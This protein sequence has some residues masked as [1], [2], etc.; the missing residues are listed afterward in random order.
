MKDG[1]KAAVVLGVG[2]GITAIYLATREVKAKPPEPPPGKATFYGLVANATTGNPLPGVKVTF[3]SLQTN[4]DNGGYYAFINLD[5]GNYTLICEKEGYEMVSR[6]ITL[7]PGD[8]SLNIGMVPIPVAEY[9][10]DVSVAAPAVGYVTKS[11]DKPAYGAGEVVTLTAI[12]D[13]WAVG[14][15]EFDHWSGDASGTS[16]VT[17]VTMDRNKVVV[18]HFVALAANLSGIVT[19]S[20]T[21]YALAGVKVTIDGKV[22][23]TDASGAYAFAGLTPGSYTVTFEKAGYETITR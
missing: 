9:T 12:L 13:S 1:K 19:D 17:T 2:A 22:D 14:S 6:D 11:P 20:D 15:Y 18:A 21:G 8:N 23:Y 7:I 10:L 16:P 3:D 5:P 4:T